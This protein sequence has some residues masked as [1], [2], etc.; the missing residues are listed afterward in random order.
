MRILRNATLLALSVS[1]L[2]ACASGGGA[3]TDEALPGEGVAVQVENNLIPPTSLTIWLVSTTGA[4]ELLGTVSPSET[5]TLAATEARFGGDYRLVAET[6]AGRELASREFFVGD[7]T[8]G[9]EWDLNAN[10]ISV[11]SR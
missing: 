1:A 11:R 5:K 7:D 9:V 6:T 2:T 10:M 3:A 8:T 4:R